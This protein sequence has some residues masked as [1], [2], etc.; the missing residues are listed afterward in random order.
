M[1]NTYKYD[2]AIHS[3]SY[4]T[5]EMYGA[6]GDG[7]TNDTTA[8]QNAVNNQ[9]LIV[10]DST[11]NYVITDAVRLKR[12]TVLD[13][14]GATL[15]FPTTGG[16]R[17]FVNFLTT[18]TNF[19]AYNGNGNITIKN[20]TIIGGNISFAHGG[21]ILLENIKFKNGLS[22][23]FLEICACKNY[24]IR[25]CS[26]EGVS[27]N[28]ISVY[29]YI[30]IDPATYY[31]FP[32]LPNGSAFF[33]GAKNDGI[34]LEDCYF[35]LGNGS[36][37]YGYNALGVHGVSGQSVKHKNI[38]LKNNILLGFTG[39]GFRINDMENV[40]IGGNDIRVVGDG[41]MVGDVGNVDNLVVFDNFVT[42]SSGQK[43][44]L[45]SN[46]YTN[47]TVVGNKTSGTIEPF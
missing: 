4:V 26:F 24:V 6:K 29:E 16:L 36:F 9:G 42:S 17:I 22:P 23:H 34:I 13:L 15:T 2:G 35:A 43:I 25:H 12:N 44:V 14:N 32:L 46:R 47:V 18:D 21:N 31:A 33:D 7:T 38:Y 28:N 3:A 10:F 39:C 5:P 45:T 41:I 11:K 37:A 30:N 8:I 27:D 20:G 19:T 40:Y 1:I